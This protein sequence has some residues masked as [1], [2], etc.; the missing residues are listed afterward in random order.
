MENRGTPQQEKAIDLHGRNLLVSAAAGSG[1]TAVLVERIVRMIT[2]EPGVDVDRLLV[3]TFTRAAAMEMKERIA[4]RINRMIAVN[5]EDTRLRRQAAL[6]GHASITT[7]D[8]FCLRVVRDYFGELDLDPDFR[9]GDEGELTL[10]Q[11][12][13]MEK[14][15]EMYYEEGNPDFLEFAEAY[16]G[17]KG[18]YRLEEYISKVYRFAESCP[19]PEDWLR[20][21]A[22]G[23]EVSSME[24][25]EQLP[26]MDFLKKFYRMLFQELELQAQSLVGVYIVMD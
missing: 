26:F 18:D 25:M 15:L 10:L 12:D 7:I 2:Q 14:L 23:F 5:P 1:K 3:L 11:A 16:G 8:S 22:E 21:A 4:A 6:L 13:C 20:E 19:Y 9:V 24:E 17:G